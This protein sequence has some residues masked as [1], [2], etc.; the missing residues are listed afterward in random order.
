MNSTKIKQKLPARKKN[1]RNIIAGSILAAVAGWTTIDNIRY[2][3]LETQVACSQY[4]V[5]PRS[6]VGRS[7]DEFY[8]G[9]MNMLHD[10]AMWDRYMER[11]NE[12]NKV[13]MLEDVALF[14]DADGDG[15]VYNPVT[16][17]SYPVID[18]Q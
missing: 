1:L 14:P 9:E 12:L 17:K 16:G 8:M 6:D 3:R 7:I 4:A 15:I 2:N 10:T 13:K 5:V 18:R 11:Y